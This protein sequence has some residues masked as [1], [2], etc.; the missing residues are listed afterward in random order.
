MTEITLE[1]IAERRERVLEERNKHQA[2]MRDAQLELDALDV[3]ERRIRSETTPQPSLPLPGVETDAPTAGAQV[4]FAQA[5]RDAVQDLHSM[6]F[7]VFDVE[8]AL[9]KRG[10][11]L[12]ANNT[13]TRITLELIPMAEKGIITRTFSGT[14]KNPNRYRLGPPLSGD[15]LLAELRGAKH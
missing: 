4:S 2:A 6:E 13:R 5:V 9:K 11:V 12:P 10:A 14:G 8:E 3:M 15:A 1:Q 7:T